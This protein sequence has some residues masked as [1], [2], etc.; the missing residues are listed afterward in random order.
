MPIEPRPP[1]LRSP[2]KLRCVSSALPALVWLL[3]MG[4][5]SGAPPSS[6]ADYISSPKLPAPSAG[7]YA[8]VPQTP[9]DPVIASTTKSH[10]WDASLSG[11]AAGL[12]LDFLETGQ[13]ITD[14]SAREAVW[15]AGYPYPVSRIRAWNTPQASPPPEA[16]NLWLTDIKP[17]I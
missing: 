2:R 4:C 6:V 17:D 14:W 5:R 13:P 11:A 15:R 10:N 12:A 8:R 9:K 7:T 1:A 16:L 3:F